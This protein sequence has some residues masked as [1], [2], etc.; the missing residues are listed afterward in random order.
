MNKSTEK[1]KYILY[2]RKSTESEDR[3]VLSIDSQID[4]LKRI[5]GRENISVIDIMSESKS[6]KTLGRP[7]F[8]K[9]IERIVRGEA[10]GILCWKLDRLARNFIDGGKVI[11]MI[12]HGTIKHIRTFERSYFPQDNVILMSLEFG[13]ANQYSRDLSVNV[14][15]G[16]R[17]KAEMGWFPTRPPIGYLN[18]RNGSKEESIIVK[19]PDRFVLVRKMW[20]LML[21]GKYSVS[22]VW[23]MANSTLRLKNRG[24][25]KLSQSNTF[26]IFTNPFYY[27]MYEMPRGS[28]NWHQGKHEP[29]ITI[30]EYD[31]VQIL[32]GNKSKPRKKT[33]DFAFTGLIKCGECGAAITAEDK[34]KVQKCGKTHDYTYYHCT[35][36]INHDCS[37]KAIVEDKLTDEIIGKVRELDL[38]DEFHLWAMK[39]LKQ[40]QES[41]SESRNTILKNQQRE[42]SEVVRKLDRYI[43]MR[44]NNELSK[45]EFREKK[46][47]MIKE[48]ARLTELL[49]DT[50]HRVTSWVDNMEN[51]FK[52]IARAEEKLKTGTLDEKKQILSALGSNRTIIDKKLLLDMEE[53]L[54]PVK[55]LS[56][57]VRSVHDRFEP[58]K[59]LYMQKDFDEMYSKIP[60]LWT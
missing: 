37:Q 57:A 24:G 23:R 49:N 42:Y 47:A 45:D 48:K 26:C 16:M 2:A 15:R 28:G 53:E 43:E 60:E 39:Q 13:M 35:K 5:A 32:L 58:H 19:D 18:Q 10:D 51:V 14:T 9:L 20:D 50:D 29:M 34:H 44:A 31:K 56:K 17:R 25:G 55:K 11:E 21:S 22:E 59:K 8:A 36:K 6:A 54:L 46:S 40:E 7:V 41:E 1:L 27:G 33:H 3:Q 4:E 38:T 52:F 12:Q 30:D